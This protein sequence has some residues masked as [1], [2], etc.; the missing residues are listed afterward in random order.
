LNA[1][2]FNSYSNYKLKEDSGF[3]SNF[4]PDDVSKRFKTICNY[5]KKDQA[6]YSNFENYRIPNRHEILSSKVFDS[7][8]ARS[9]RVS[10]W[11]ALHSNEE[12]F[13]Y[14]D[15]KSAEPKLKR[16]HPIS[17]HM[18]YGNKSTENNS[19]EK[20]FTSNFTAPRYFSRFYV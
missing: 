16:M 17:K 14:R 19:F 5:R 6:E 9:D 10:I 11:N 3:P 18:E 15:W 12:C 1:E 2:E 20:L 7:D 13:F 8:N 4:K